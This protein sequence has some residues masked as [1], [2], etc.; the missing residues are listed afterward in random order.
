M[1]TDTKSAE[2]AYI[3]IR[4]PD[5]PVQMTRR[6]HFRHTHQNR[7]LLEKICQKICG[8][9]QSSSMMSTLCT[10]T[11]RESWNR[12]FPVNNSVLMKEIHM[13]EVV[14]SIFS[15]PYR[16]MRDDDPSILP[17]KDTPFL[18]S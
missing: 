14:S 7:K 6:N 9:G 11:A 13:S 1:T 12:I 15:F 5:R 10:K 18:L 17:V 3:D 4:A 8:H 16:S 2:L